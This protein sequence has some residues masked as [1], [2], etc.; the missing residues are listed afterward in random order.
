MSS[1]SD[2]SCSNVWK[3]KVKWSPLHKRRSEEL[4]LPSF[5]RPLLQ[6]HLTLQ[7]SAVKE[8][9]PIFIQMLKKFSRWW[10]I[11][12]FCTLMCYPRAFVL[13]TNLTIKIPWKGGGSRPCHKWLK[14]W[15]T[16]RLKCITNIL[17][18]VGLVCAQQH[19]SQMRLSKF[20]LP[21]D[22][23]SDK[24]MFVWAW[25]LSLRALPPP[26]NQSHRIGHLFVLT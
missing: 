12:S 24:W 20:I 17:R 8:E 1:D 22:S 14:S 3:W 7:F 9:E 18:G 16:I 15:N 23:L 25:K 11:F 21:P 5:L 10:I 19:V 4:S 26:P 6:K 2:D 13:K